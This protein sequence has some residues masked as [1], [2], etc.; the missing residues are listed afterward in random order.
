MYLQRESPCDVS[1]TSERAC[2]RERRAAVLAPRRDQEYPHIALATLT[3]AKPSFGG[4][5]VVIMRVVSKSRKTSYKWTA[6]RTCVMT[7]F[8][9]QPG[10]TVQQTR[11]FPDAQQK[12][13]PSRCA[14]ASG[15]PPSVFSSCSLR[16]VTKPQFPIFHVA[17]FSKPKFRALP[18]LAV[19]VGL[20]AA[21]AAANALLDCL[22]GSSFWRSQFCRRVLFHIHMVTKWRCSIFAQ[23]HSDA[24]ALMTV[25]NKGRQAPPKAVPAATYALR[26]NAAACRVS[27]CCSTEGTYSLCPAQGYNGFQRSIPLAA[28]CH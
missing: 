26:P 7:H 13:Q 3:R 16:I 28:R 18:L 9:Y 4:P 24:E 5:L 15:V 1:A 8:V 11:M 19:G 10:A 23:N 21:N 27:K 12:P 14:R 20:A 25:R 22:S 17:L 6:A 2:T